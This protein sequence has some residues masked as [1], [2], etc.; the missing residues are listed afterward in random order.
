MDLPRLYTPAEVAQA[1]G[2]TAHYV[3]VQARHGGWPH[4]KVARGAIR[5]SAED[6]AAVLELCASTHE[7]VSTQSGLTQLSR[8]RRRRQAS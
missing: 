7:P 3:E 4:R 5:F 8:V 1:M 6:Y 2:Q